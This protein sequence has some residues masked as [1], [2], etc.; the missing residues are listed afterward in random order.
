MLHE[1]IKYVLGP[2]LVAQGAYI[3]RRMPDLPEAEGPRTGTVGHGRLIRILVVGDSSAAGVGAET[4]AEALSGCLL[5]NLESQCQVQWRLIAKTG[6]T[7]DDAICYLRSIP[8]ESYDFAISALGVNDALGARSA[9][10]YLK[11]QGQFVD[12]LR[13]KFSVKQLVLSALPPLNRFPSLPEPLSWYLGRTATL[14]NDRL[15]RL[16]DGAEDCQFIAA[17]FQFRDTMLARD[18]FHPGPSIYKIWGQL[19]AEKVLGSGKMGI[20]NRQAEAC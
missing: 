17:N 20:A 5:K 11:K 13:E 6:W 3:R 4:Q 1:F 14:Y 12:L 10:F 18:G 19:V 9:S 7:T 16:V 8:A 15:A 2:V